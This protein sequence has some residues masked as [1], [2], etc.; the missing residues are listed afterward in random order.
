MKRIAWPQAAIIMTA[1]L[2]IAAVEG[3]AIWKGVDGAA[4]AAALSVIAGLAGW[5]AGRGG[6]R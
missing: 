4:L 2:G 5:R 3:L 1:I 6:G